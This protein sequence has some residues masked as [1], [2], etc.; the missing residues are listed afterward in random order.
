MITPF[1]N[2]RHGHRQRLFIHKD[3]EGIL[4]ETEGVVV[5]HEQV[6]R[7]ISTLTGCSLAQGDEK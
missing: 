2:T 7:L 3:L 6:I 4:A 1:I 5:F